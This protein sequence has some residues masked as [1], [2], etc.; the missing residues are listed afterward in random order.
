MNLS[1]HFLIAMPDTDDEMFGGSLVY[2]CEHDE[3]GAM[4]VIVNKPSDVKM[5][6][7]FMS[8]EQATPFHLRDEFLLTGGPVQVDRGFVLH[9]PQGEWQSSLKVNERIALTVSRDILE[10]LGNREQVSQVLVCIGYAAWSKGQLEQELANNAWL[11]VEADTDILFEVP[12]KLRYAA[13]LQKLGISPEKLMGKA[14]Y[15]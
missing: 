9:T 12:P 10:Q 2:V 3:N 13:A 8:N 6:S 15:A 4:G 1:N 11:T 7:I 5:D 14:A